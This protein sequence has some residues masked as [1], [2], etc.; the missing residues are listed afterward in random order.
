MN[1]LIFRDFFGIFLNFSEFIL[2][3]FRF[4][5]VE[6]IKKSSFYCELT[7]QVTRWWSDVSPRDD[8]YMRHVVHMCARMC[9][10][11]RV[12]TCALV[13]SQV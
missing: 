8:V 2:D 12:C 5:K 6:E 13:W 11:V 4:L 9:T 7:W 3:L 1:F 10:R